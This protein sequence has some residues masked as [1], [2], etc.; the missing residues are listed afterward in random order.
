MLLQHASSFPHILNHLDV[1][2]ARLPHCHLACF[3]PLTA[4]CW[5]SPTLSCTLSAL[6]WPSAWTVQVP[7]SYLL[8]LHTTHLQ[9]LICCQSLLYMPG[10]CMHA[11]GVCRTVPADS[12][13]TVCILRFVQQYACINLH[14]SCMCLQHFIA[15]QG[16][17]DTSTK[18]SCEVGFICV[19]A[20]RQRKSI[21]GTYGITTHIKLYSD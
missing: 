9:L 20:A 18:A 14:A 12:E 19:P 16:A 3:L 10:C 6:L 1:A 7:C 2:T 15:C 11:G 8:Y 17:F 13:N 5:M 4:S 21:I